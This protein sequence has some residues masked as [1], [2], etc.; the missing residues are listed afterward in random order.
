MQAKDGHFLNND[1]MVYHVGKPFV[2]VPGS[3]QIIDVNGPEFYVNCTFELDNTYTPVSIGG[4]TIHPWMVRLVDANGL[5]FLACKFVNNRYYGSNFEDRNVLAIYALNSSFKVSNQYKSTGTT[6]FGA[7]YTG[8]ITGVSKFD[9]FY[10]GI[11][12][13]NSAGTKPVWIENTSFKD[14]TRG[15]EGEN[16]SAPIIQND[17]FTLT[18]IGSDPDSW[19]TPAG[20]RT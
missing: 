9:N 7:V 10:V 15:I 4:E 1:T 20:D 19:N 12:T 18:Q 3:R 8:G 5:Q 16:L 2:Y 17:T 6:P 14:V 13:L 11:L